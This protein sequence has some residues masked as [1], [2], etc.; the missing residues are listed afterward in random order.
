MSLE[1]I[2]ISRVFQD[3]EVS[4]ECIEKNQ[5]ILETLKC[6]ICLDFLRNL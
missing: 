4:F 1:T 3:R 2:K 6:P 5:K